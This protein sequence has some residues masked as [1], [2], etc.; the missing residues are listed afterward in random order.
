[1]D[2]RTFLGAG[3]AFAASLALAP[4]RVGASAVAVDG[5][6]VTLPEPDKSGGKPLMECLMKR[7]SIHKPG[8]K[9]LSMEHIS[10]ILW[11]AC[12][13][14]DESGKRVIP[15]ARNRQ[16]IEAY[17]VLADGVWQYNPQKHLIRR[18]IMGDRRG[19]FDG[20]AAILLFA[21]PANDE[22]AGMH[23]GSMYMNVAL[24]CAGEGIH[25]CVKV[26]RRSAL[27]A[28]LPLQEDWKVL[29]LQCLSL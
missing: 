11:A 1:M 19:D 18:V 4:S 7:R 20:S 17:I 29:A 6:E 25:N 26:Q 13:I 22:Y 9:D 10:N 23:V 21:A 14:N 8:T 16:R 24:Y 27:D 2:R 12:G 5:K 28:E 3:T 15:T